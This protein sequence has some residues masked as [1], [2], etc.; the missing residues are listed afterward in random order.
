MRKIFCLSVAIALFACS[1]QPEEFKGLGGIDLGE[2]FSSIPE[3]KSFAKIMDNEYF[4]G[5]YEMENGIGPVSRLSV[6]T[7]DSGKVIQVKFL[8]AQN[9]DVNRIDKYTAELQPVGNPIKMPEGL[10]VKLFINADSSVT[11]TKIKSEHKIFNNGVPRYEYGYA[12]KEYHERQRE[13]AQKMFSK[14]KRGK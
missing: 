5:D 1:H 11:L 8:Q 4:I 12:N 3:S 9:T 10:D 7:N 6:T 13:M 14:M 2:D